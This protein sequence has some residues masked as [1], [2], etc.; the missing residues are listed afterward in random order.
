MKKRYAQDIAPIAR[1]SEAMNAANEFRAKAG[2]DAIFEVEEYNSLDPFLHGQ[3]ANNRY[4][5]RNE[6]IKETATITEAVMAEAI[7]DPEFRKVMGDQ[8]WK[9]TQ[10]TGGSYKDLIEAIKLGIMD[11]PISQ[12][13]FSQI[14]QSMLK[15]AGIE[16][17]GAAGQRAIANAI[18]LGMYA[19][20]DKPSIQFQANRGYMAGGIGSGSTRSGS[21]GRSRSHSNKDDEYTGSES[22]I[23]YD[24]T[25]G[26]PDTIIV[27]NHGPGSSAWS[28]NDNEFKDGNVH[29]SLVPWS[30]V[31]DGVRA[32][33]GNANPDY[34]IV[35]SWTDSDEYAEARGTLPRTHY[36]I[37]KKTS[38]PKEAK[39]RRKPDIE[40]GID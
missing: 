17:Y 9:I 14:R 39:G 31:P 4:Q 13:R 10:H 35:T 7:K 23:E 15:K 20:L 2:P 30:S 18:D 29:G 11:N 40:R 12:N 6:L 32:Y 22:E 38:A 3:T 21:K 26:I 8:F 36:Q 1:A 5:S 19:G 16:R 24:D 37:T 25:L 27:G 28:S 34:Y 33:I